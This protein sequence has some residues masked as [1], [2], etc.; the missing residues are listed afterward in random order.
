METPDDRQMDCNDVRPALLLASDGELS[1]L[2][3]RLLDAHL[4]TCPTCRRDRT[5]LARVEQ[6]LSECRDAL[7]SLETGPSVPRS[8]RAKSFVL[9]AAAAAALLL[10][11]WIRWPNHA[12]T[13][14][15]DRVRRDAAVTRAGDLDSSEVVALSLPLAPIGSPFSDGSLPNPEIRGELVVGPDGLRHIRLAN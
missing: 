1:I 11:V 8:E 5:R 15:V 4:A 3:G 13:N 6:R 14:A 9:C 10:A 12:D 2:E 7:D